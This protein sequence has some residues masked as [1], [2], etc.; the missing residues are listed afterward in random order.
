MLPTPEDTQMEN[1]DS[2]SN[3]SDIVNGFTDVSKSSSAIHQ[4]DGWEPAPGIGYT[5]VA[6][7]EIAE[8]QM[9]GKKRKTEHRPSHPDHT[10]LRQK[11]EGVFVQISQLIKAS[12][13]PLPT[14]TGDGS[15]LD[16]A[17]P[18]GLWEDLKNVLN[19]H[20]VET[21]IEVLQE[22]MSGNLEDDR[23]YIMER[24]IQLAS[25]LPRNSKH[26][27][28]LTNTF[29]TQLWDT[30][31]HPPISLALSIYGL[32][33][34]KGKLTK[35]RYLGET[36][37]YR[38]ADG[39]CNNLLNPQ[40][41]AANTPYARSVPPKAPQSG[42]L[43]DPGVLFDSLMARKEYEEHPNKISSMMFYLASIIIHDL[44]RTSHQDFN[45]SN[46]S[47]YLDLAP[48]YGSNQ[49]EQN[50]MRMLQDGKIKPDCF[51]EKRLLGFPPGVGC[52][53]I[54]FNRFHNYIVT[55][56]AE[57]NEG[58]RFTKPGHHVHDANR[59]KL[60]AKYDNDLFQTGRLIVCGLY[61]NII[62]C[63][64][65]RTILNTN[66]IHS[67]WNLDPRVNMDTKGSRDDGC[68][69]ATGNQVSA[70]F[71]LVY[72]WHAT[73][74]DRDD[75]WTQDTYRKMFPGKEP[76]EVPMKE[77]LEGLSQWERA[78]PDDPLKRP[79]ADMKRDQNYNLPDDEL[80]QI[81]TES[82][83]DCAGSFGAN[84]VPLV[85]KAV[86]VLGIKQA[87]SWNL[88]TLNEFRKF[89][90]LQPHKTFEDINSDEKVANQLRHLY[91]H[92]DYV[93]LYPGIAVEEAK[94]P[95][96]PGSGLCPGFTISRAVLSDAV[97]LVRGDRLCTTDYHP[98]NLTNWGFNEAN[99]DTTIDRGCVM[100]KL[101]IR[102][103]PNHF[104]Q[105]SVYAHYPFTTP[106]ENKRIL[107]DLG[108]AS[109]YSYDRPSYVAPSINIYSY[110][111][112][113]SVLGN[114][115]AFKITWGDA[116]EF[117]MGEGGRDAD[118]SGDKKLNTYQRRVMDK[119]LYR[120][121]WT[122]QV[123][124]FYEDIT[125]KLLQEKSYKI[126]GINQVDLV[127]D[128]GNLAHVHFSANV[129]SLPLKTQQFPRGVYSETELYMVMALVFMTVFFDL[130]P[131]K[132]FPMRQAARSTTQQLGKIVE[133]NVEAVDLTGYIAGIVDS[134]TQEDS[135]LK[136]FGVHMVRRLL[137]T[138]MSVSEV[139]WSQILPTAGGMVAIQGQLFAQIIEF[140]L[141]DEQKHH[142]PEINRLAKENTQQADEI[143]VHYTMEAARLASTV[144]LSRDVAKSVTIQDQGK[145]IH[146]KKGQR[147][148]VNLVSAS[149]D[150]DAFPEA[151]KV[152]LDRPLDS[153]I[154]YGYGPHWCLGGDLSR[155][156]LTAMLKTV[157]K[158][159]GLR[160]T[161][162]VQG[163][164]K[165]VAAPGGF[166]AYMT[167]D[168][169]SFFPFPTSMK[170]NWD[171]AI[172][173]R[174]RNGV[175]RP[176]SEMK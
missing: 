142:L 95:M 52:L 140:Y 115:D 34:L 15:Y 78:L 105:N 21:C 153:Y 154:H 1:A 116:L 76:H 125:A 113:K 65:V 168:H 47:S 101:L 48:L 167:E 170:V 62:L 130:D 146:V 44:F 54:S 147:V 108:L 118:L 22:K 51:S 32:L 28:E 9:N 132:S 43:P 8:P 39:S 3:G 23:T 30:L 4:L 119:A 66:R 13:R 100:Y 158:L 107:K 171:D 159:S 136:D 135:A 90:G 57:I 50:A 46:T 97:A 145:R 69:L 84:R 58:G 41:G 157:G 74:S 143:L 120:D 149:K 151:E 16:D 56:L 10:P 174:K 36:H 79:F 122:Q 24:V 92:P 53:L 85:M 162:G 138:D 106:P 11:I 88:A 70:E 169:S 61:V 121:Q 67:T 63:D 77:L 25:G 172:T 133:G 98:K 18:T 117:L 42:N 87:R 40:L 129:F 163:E 99:Y 148:F 5:E 124:K 12:G 37:Q 91:D 155:I 26:G 141:S 134:V 19:V 166:F 17:V 131:A 94:V 75:K 112:A 35:S 156:A 164:I 29:I 104:R 93:E 110:A 80:V 173:S 64:Y 73:I 31:K 126:A 150:E 72:R 86:E 89:C 111:A 14:Q 128:V 6:T 71:N 139:T 55:Q 49:K 175:K 83:E 137:E 2:I 160:R 82:I 103:F 27:T 60:L 102:A 176:F 152:R 96:T 114:T 7:R 144:G 68:P 123:M 161:P 109:D 20:N 59:K 45:I 127:R 165:K 38:Q 33:L 81:L